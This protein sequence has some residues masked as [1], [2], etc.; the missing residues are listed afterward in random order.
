MRVALY[1]RVSTGKQAEKDLCIPDQFHQMEEWC[2]RNG[3]EV[4]QKYVE[5]GKSGT[6]AQRR[7]VFQQLMADACVSPTP[8]DAVIVHSFSRFFR[9]LIEMA[10]IQRKLKE[11]GSQ[12]ISITQQT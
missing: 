6:S 4:V 9:N 7:K 12:L 1:A 11:H 3:Y 2:K 8:Y 5:P 10:L